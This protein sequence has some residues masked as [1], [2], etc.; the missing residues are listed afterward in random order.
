MAA[1]Q[2]HERQLAALTQDKSK[3]NLKLGLILGGL[4]VVLGGSL[5]GYLVYKSSKENEARIAAEQREKDRLKEEAET[6]IVDVRVASRYGPHD[7]GMGAAI[8]E[9]YL[10]ALD[11]EMQG[12]N[13]N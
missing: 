7:L 3:K 9:A 2:A 6:T 11:A 8:A 4:V 5:T 13:D 1:Q 12:L 10:D